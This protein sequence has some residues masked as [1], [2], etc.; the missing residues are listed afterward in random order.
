VYLTHDHYYRDL[1]HKPM[2]DRAKT[3]FDH[4]DSLETE[5]LVQ[6]LQELKAGKIAVL[7]TY[8]FKTHARTPVTTLVHPKRI[9]IV[10]GILIFT[11]P[12]LC[13]ELDLKVFI[14]ADTDTRVI[15]RIRR[16]TIERG[17]TLDSIMAQYQTFVKPMHAQ[18]VEPSKAQADVIVNSETGHSQNIAI[19]MLKNHLSVASGM[20]NEAEQERQ[21]TAVTEALA[22]AA[23]AAATTDR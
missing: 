4:P 14:D 8:D 23:A 2:E 6:H 22:S 19:A 5:L 1:S 17:R 3:N 10:E 12:L 18:W 16:D 20:L 7:P 13:K 11:H 9:I 21:T 15:R